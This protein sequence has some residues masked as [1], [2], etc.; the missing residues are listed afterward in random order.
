ML[1]RARSSNADDLIGGPRT[2]RITKVAR[3]TEPD[4]PIAIN[5]EGDGGKPY[6]PCKSMRRVLVTV[7]GNDGN[8]YV[9]RSMT[10][11]RDDKVLFGG[12]AVGGI[13]IS[14]M[15]DLEREMT[16]ALTVTKARRAPYVV[17]PLR[18]EQAAAPK[19]TKADLF[20]DAR[21]KAREGSFAL[22]EWRA[23][24]PDRARAALDEI[25]AELQATAEAAD[26]EADNAGGNSGADLEGEVV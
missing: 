4:Q 25:A 23:G 18:V 3:S 22:D 21:A 20:A 7:W 6:L 15:T 19:R 5:F 9:G 2:I 16:L 12:I 8:A 1:P 11:Y 13:R 10:L 17:K 24:L 26:A 14:H